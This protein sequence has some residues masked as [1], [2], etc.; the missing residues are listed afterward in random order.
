MKRI[1]CQRCRDTGRITGTEQ[2]CD[3]PQICYFPLDAATPDMTA[4]VKTRAFNR[5]CPDCLG[6]APAFKFMAIAQDF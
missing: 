2:Y 5:G 4:T 3:L 6:F 1:Y